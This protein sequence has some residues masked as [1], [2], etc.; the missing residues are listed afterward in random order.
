MFALFSVTVNSI[1]SIKSP[2]QVTTSKSTKVHINKQCEVV[3][4]LLPSACCPPAGDTYL[5][6]VGPVVMEKVPGTAL[7]RGGRRSEI[8]QHSSVSQNQS[9]EFQTYQHAF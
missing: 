2:L 9:V 7:V 4:F 3:N 1:I 5:T 8:R 6:G